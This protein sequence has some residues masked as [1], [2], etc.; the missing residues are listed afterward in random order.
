MI[1]NAHATSL[2]RINKFLK[3]EFSEGFREEMNNMPALFNIMKTE[4]LTGKY[5]EIDFGGGIVD[6]V[7]QLG[8]MW[9]NEFESF[10]SELDVAPKGRGY[11]NPMSSPETDQYVLGLEDLKYNTGP[12]FVTARFDTTKSIATFALTD[13]AVLI[14]SM[15]GSLYNAVDQDLKRMVHGIK[16]T[17]QRMAYGSTDGLIGNLGTQAAN[18]RV[19]AEK[20]RGKIKAVAKI[21][22][23]NIFSFVKGMSVLV[24]AGTGTGYFMGKVW[25][26]V[27][28]TVT[29]TPYVRILIDKFGGTVNS[30]LLDTGAKFV[31]SISHTNWDAGE[32]YSRQFKDATDVERE[33]HGL[34]DILFRHSADHASPITGAKK[35]M[36]GINFDEFEDLRPTIENAEDA[37]IDE[38]DLD[39]MRDHIDLTYPS[40]TSISLVATTHGVVNKVKESLYTSG[41]YRWDIDN[42]K[43]TMEMGRKNLVHDGFEYQKDKFAR[44]GRVALLDTT[45]ISELQIKDFSWVTQGDQQGV[46]ERRDGTE[47][48]EGIM[49][50]YADYAVEAFRAHAGFINVAE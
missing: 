18:T 22:P 33:Y 13:E 7:R 19:A 4:Q 37:V 41:S 20:V 26:I 23:T 28:K 2:D 11:N 27:H 17:H 3:V 1:T 44:K 9:D 35:Y 29:G 36:F 47:I 32:V 21:Y 34:E 10:G 38:K 50:K 31:T 14:G 5:K 6:N 15:D 24:K 16:H 42:R 8:A 49:T 46:L 12:E 40:D 25:Q 43:D 39:D 48:F 45:L 30:V